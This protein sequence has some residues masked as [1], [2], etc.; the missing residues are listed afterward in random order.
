MRVA[1]I[2]GRGFVGAALCQGL[3]S[4]G[5]DVIPL[6]RPGFD[7]LDRSTWKILKGADCV[8]HAAGG[9][10]A[11]S[12]ET[13]RVN[14]LP[15]EALAEACNDA[16]VKRFIYLSTGRVYG[17]GPVAAHPGMECRP[18]GDYPLSKS[19]AERV[20]AE[21]FRGQTSIARLYYPYGPGQ[22]SPRVFPRLVQSVID[23]AIITCAETGGPRLSVSHIDDLVQ[24][25]IGDFVTA[26]TPPKVANL[27]SHSVVTIES[28][29]RQLAEHLGTPLRLERT[30]PAL[31]EF[32]QPYDGFAWRPFRIEDVLPD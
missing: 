14:L 22:K 32:S 23:G 29:A 26:E 8:V 25:L 17:Y 19:L 1:V 28:L 16:G 4:S 13:F 24:V 5:I 20:I 2:G 3:V 27:A 18:T 12:W 6:G 10:A 9:R 31:D 15:C 7:L 21:T 11:S 30:G